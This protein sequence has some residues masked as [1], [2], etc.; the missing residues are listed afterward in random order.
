M[1]FIIKPFAEIIIKSKPVR[2]RYL[3]F[4][5]VNI[6]LALAN[7]WWNWYS[8]F[9]WDKWEVFI[10]DSIDEYTYNS[11]ITILSRMPWVESFLEVVDH[12]FSNFD[13]I[14]N[15]A[16][17]I[18]CDYVEWKSFAVR[19]K[20]F[21]N[22]DFKSTD[23][24]R[25][26]WWWL[27][28][29][30]NS[31]VVKLKNP[32][33]TVNIEIRENRFY[34]V[35]SKFLWIGWY[36]TWTQD[37]VLSL[38][39]GWFD[40]TVSSFSLMKRWAKLDYLFFNLGWNSHEI[41]VKQV[42]NYLRKNFS[43]WYKARF[44]TI[45]FEEIIPD[46]IKNINHK[47]RWII[48][49]RLFLMAADI[50]S[51]K[52]NYYAI[53]KWDSLGQ[54]SS[55]TL[56]NMFVVDKASETLV[57]RPLIGFN[58]QEIVDLSKK[59]WTYSFACNMPEYCGVISD[60]PSTWAKLEKVLEEEKKFDFSLLYKAIDERKTIKIDQVLDSLKDDLIHIETSYIPWDNEI[61]IDLREELDFKNNPLILDWIKVLNIPFFDVNY[62]FENLDQAK[63][64][65]FYCDKW[66]MSK[67]HAEFLYNK[68]YKNIKIYKPIF[69]DWVCRIKTW[70]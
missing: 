68:W 5:Q 26:I 21:W 12:E 46:L 50:L 63:T 27:K 41:A 55:Q 43:S 20:R 31:S 35:K 23:L 14:F 24:E 10:D 17:K 56:K 47:Y 39:S 4:L 58:K 18:Y 57:L 11:L 29:H 19:V 52:N 64:Y 51:K 3:N 60:K 65:L 49:K 36:P 62:D 13:D 48:L 8:K 61:V 40:S 15:E 34:L 66:I 6:N 70:K 45:N 25:Y 54:V 69:D 28:Q 59:I 67:T 53:V 38:I 1:K 37:K 7:I 9:S 30:T 42:S 44:T 33:V 22:H 2:K 32:D 16:K